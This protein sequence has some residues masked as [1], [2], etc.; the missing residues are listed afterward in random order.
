LLLATASRFYLVFLGAL[1]ACALVP[2]LFGLSG[3]VVQSGSMEP[4]ISTGDVVL[5]HPVPAKAPAPMG[6]VITF[7]APVGSAK[8]G[9]MLHRLVAA[10]KNGTLVTA[11]D[12]NHNPDST[13]L[14]RRNIISQGCLLIPW[15]GLPSYWVTTGAFLPLGIW[16]L[17]T[18]G[19]LMIGAVDAAS[20]QP[21]AAKPPPDPEGPS[22]CGP[23]VEPREAAQA[24]GS[25]RESISSLLNRIR[26]ESPLLNRIRESSL[27]NRMRIDT[28]S[29]A[30][31]LVAFFTAAALAM[32]PLGMAAAAFTARAAS[33]GNSWG[34][35]G[36][37][38]KLA[39]TTS[40]SAST[41]GIAFATQPRVTVQD[42]SGNPVSVSSAPV[43]LTITTPAGATLTCTAN[44]TNAFLGV[45]TF[46]GCRIDKAGTYTLTATS[47]ILT[48]AVSASFT[49]T[50]GPAAKLAFTTSPSS[51]T[52]GTVFATQPVVAVQDAG[53]NPVA[54]S[55]ASVTLSITTPAG[56]VLT[57]TTNPANAVSGVATF[58][59]CKI[60]NP[61]TYTL[62][63][64]ASGL[65]SAVSASFAVTASPATQLAFTVNPSSSTGGT[66]FPTQPVVAVQDS[67]GSTVTSSS[68]LVDLSITTPAGATLTCTEEPKNAVSGV[69]TFAG[70]KI[71]KIGTYTLT[72]VSSGL[73]NAVSASFTITVGPAVKLGFTRV[74]A[75]T[76]VNTS[77]SAQPRVAI[78]DA[79]GNT[80][81]T[82]SA[83]VTLAITPPTG[84]ATLN[85]CSSNPLTTSSGVASFANC[86]I[87][88]AGTYTLTATASGLTAAVSTSFTIFGPATKL[89]FVTS[90]SSSNGGTA[91][92]T[93][94]VVAVQDAGG[95]TVASSNTS[96]TL[97][98][99]TPAGAV[100]TC[101]AN[102]TNA[103][104]GVATFAG[105][106]INLPGT[107][108]LTAATGG[109]TSGVSASFTITVGGASK[110]AF[111]TSPSGSS[112]GTTF[113]TQ[114]VVTLQDAGGNPV[115][116]SSASVTLTIT[117]AGGATLTCT[118]N[119]TSA[120]SGVATF[121]G[122]SIDKSGTYT[123]TAASSGL[124]NGVST[125]LTITAG[126]ATKLAFTT[127]PSSSTGGT[128]FG[129]QPV[130]TVQDTAGNTVTSSSASVTLA[131]TPPTGGATLNCNPNPRTASSGV[132]SF[133]SCKINLAGTYTLT[134]TASGLTS[135]VSASFTI[136]VGPASKLAFSTSP[137]GS[138]SGTAF[139]TQPV[140][141][142]Q[143]AG[144]NT[145]TSSSASVTLAITSA[146]G[147]TLT[148]TA[149][150][151][152]AV[153]GTA[154]FAGCS[155]D[156]S[157]TYT[158]TAT[159]S[160][161]SSGV[162]TSFTITAGT[163]TKLAFTRSPST[164]TAVNSSFNAQPVVTIQDASGNTVTT[165]TAS[166][167]LAITTPAGATLTCTTNPANA[168]AGVATFA[169]CRINTAGVYTLTATSGVLAA[170]TS[171]SFTI[172]GAASKLA[173]TTSPSSST[174]GTAFGTQPVVTVQD[175]GGRT[176]TN[177]GATVTLAITAPTGGATLTCSSSNSRTASSGV[178]TFSGCSIDL[179]GTYTLTATSGTLTAAVSNSFAITAGGGSG[180][181]PASFAQASPAQAKPAPATPAPT[182]T[183]PAPAAPAAPAKPAAPT[184]A[185][186]VP[187]TPAPAA[188]ATTG[189]HDA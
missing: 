22:G 32:A 15:I 119:P 60:D 166:V 172:Y 96:V 64:A 58:A 117:S 121:A 157:G 35:A 168:V 86:R 177:S 87:D 77:F 122:C 105:C 25:P 135:A 44:P 130:V 84:G 186:S 151:S 142:V 51:S 114:P 50:S 146:G 137:S 49:I 118:A 116:S 159:A 174:G 148:C 131:I 171:S 156:K 178:A 180:I 8:S 90:P 170:A 138:S 103:V 20:R 37:A 62:T 46:A 145:V 163:A 36:P 179:A 110:L 136:T 124:S 43:T 28:G 12:A 100:L 11:G 127:S 52:G 21:P 107:Y 88:T 95:N 188:P 123:L 162:S 155:I 161:L 45:A 33:I 111:S 154:T 48:S 1:A 19:A 158:L 99:T 150:P 92:A 120:V 27:L 125:S 82:S 176:V 56:A 42:P 41:G 185:P 17:L 70:C 139:A 141:S 187:A 16:V 149:N 24:T 59:G 47:G 108:T 39:F 153:S 147:A 164:S 55:T 31:A 79:G 113:A 91:S 106:K 2:M 182:P 143:D 160:G 101:T 94:P 126:T 3:S 6:R 66:A 34:A 72:A 68:A 175:S 5:S 140:V 71:D 65:T 102:P 9:L 10:N 53:G 83:S 38:S 181:A 133:S 81:T 109:L 134:A 69:A 183:T 18:M 128:S 167:T 26:I 132:A 63:V 75:S 67:S 189:Q 165:S 104:A 144:G 30:V 29:A 76:A 97:S 115:T 61:G 7:R 74:P 98:I 57:C 85:N 173:F 112:S 73:T 54:S 169:G 14:A 80:R 89:A 40:P 13:P 4:H 23:D 152:N 78:L 93:Q 129:T 184:P